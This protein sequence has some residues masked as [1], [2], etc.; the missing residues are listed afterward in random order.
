MRR[1]PC[2]TVRSNPHLLQLEKDH[3]KAMKTQHGQKKKNFFSIIYLF[4][5]L[6][7]FF[8]L[9]RANSKGLLKFKPFA[10]PMESLIQKIG[11]RLRMVET[12]LLNY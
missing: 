3:A 11:Q 7:F 12:G 1:N 6:N 9:F 10:L 2:T 5:F 4:F 8:H